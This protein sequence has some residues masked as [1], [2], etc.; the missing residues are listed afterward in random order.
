ML[1]FL[2]KYQCGFRKGC[3]TQHCLL[4]ILEKWKSAVD[5]EKL[6]GVLL[7]DLPKEFDCLSHELLLAKPHACGSSIAALRLIHSYLTNRK[8]RT[9]VNLSY[10]SWEEIL[11]GVPQ[12][13]I[14]GPLLFNIFLCDLFFYCSTSS[15]MTYNELHKLM[16]S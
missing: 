6:L 3:S 5:K 16:I 9:K 4:A 2:S 13:S 7:I 1:K 14:L 11:F 10:S 12:G 8:Q 15:C